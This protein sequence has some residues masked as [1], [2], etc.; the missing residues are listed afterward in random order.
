MNAVIVSAGLKALQFGVK[1]LLSQGVLDAIRLFVVTQL[2][3]DATSE[4]KHPT[5][6]NAAFVVLEKAGDA[7]RDEAGQWISRYPWM[8]TVLDIAIKVTYAVLVKKF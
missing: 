3:A 5:A 8:S 6:K 4:D 7:T 2:H 1:V